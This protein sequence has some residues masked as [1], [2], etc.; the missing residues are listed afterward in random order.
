MPFAATGK[1]PPWL[2]PKP[3]APPGR[4][5]GAGWGI[6]DAL[7]AWPES[8]AVG[9]DIGKALG[10]QIIAPALQGALADPGARAQLV[11]LIREALVDPQ[12][13]AAARGYLVE[14]AMYVGGAVLG[15][16]VLYRV[17]TR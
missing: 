15:A 10:S 5:T 9:A 17:A 2:L 6:S 12:T 11:A 13:K 14:A 3:K 1:R 8:G 16:L 4:E 7:A